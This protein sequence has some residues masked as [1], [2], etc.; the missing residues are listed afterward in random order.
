MP[1]MPMPPMPIK[2]MRW[3]GAKRKWP[4]RNIKLSLDALLHGLPDEL[5]DLEGETGGEAVGEHPV[6]D[7]AGVEGYIVG[8]T[9]GGGRLGEGGAEEDAAY[10]L[11]EGVGADEVAGELIVFAMA[12]D[13]LDLVIRG[14]GVEIGHAEGAEGRAGTGALDVDDLVDGFGDVGQGAFAGGLDHQGVM[15]G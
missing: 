8:G 3:V 5:V 15:A 9:E 11:L 14:E 10:L 4:G 7:E 6:D 13:K 2:W 1:L 12:E